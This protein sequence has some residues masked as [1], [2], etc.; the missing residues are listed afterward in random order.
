MKVVAPPPL[1]ERSPAAPRP[2]VRRRR[3]LPGGRAVFGGFLVAVAVVGTIA[4]QNAAT[5]PPSTRYVV[6]A[7]SLPAGRSVVL[8]DLT[9]RAI[10]LPEP[11]SGR[12][13]R[14]PEQLVGRVLAATLGP[15]ELVQVSAL[16]QRGPRAGEREVSFTAEPSRSLGQRVSPGDLV[17][18]YATAGQAESTTL[19]VRSVR[20]IDRQG[21]DGA[22]FIF[23]VALAD[24]EEVESLVAAAAAGS[25][26]VVRATAAQPSPGGG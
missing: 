24:A 1:G 3:P 8:D 14:D 22:A 6:A 13:Y 12:A 7:A 10:D 5:G 18:V 23:T 2:V 15:G 17:D 19:I 11:L 9:T 26:T 20:V 21:R 16:A 4:A 25:L